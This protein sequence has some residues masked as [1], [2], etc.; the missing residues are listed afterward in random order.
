MKL[1]REQAALTAN[2]QQTAEKYHELEILKNAIEN[3]Y[4]D[5]KETQ[6]ELIEDLKQKMM[7]ADVFRMEAEA[8]KENLEEKLRIETEK[9][10]QLNQMLQQDILDKKKMKKDIGNLQSD[11]NY[12]KKQF[13]KI[14]FA[15]NESEKHHEADT[16]KRFIRLKEGEGRIKLVRREFS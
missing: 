2:F 11:L 7:E 12:A 3:K 10:S 9:G 15:K 13:Q 4:T 5:E 6:K 14:A 16:E 8:A 1:Q